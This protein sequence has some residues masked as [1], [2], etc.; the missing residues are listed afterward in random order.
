LRRW[1]VHGILLTKRDS[2]NHC[3]TIHIFDFAHKGAAAC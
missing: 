1:G 2:K 3:S